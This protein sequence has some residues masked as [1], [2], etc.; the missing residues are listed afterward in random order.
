MTEF[1]LFGSDVSL[2]LMIGVWVLWISLL[3]FPSVFSLILVLD[4]YALVACLYPLV[5]T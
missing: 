4:F 2:R 3:I 1:G 5:Y